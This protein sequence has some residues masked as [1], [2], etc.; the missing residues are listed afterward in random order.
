LISSAQPNLCIN[1]VAAKSS[2]LFF[3]KKAYQG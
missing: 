1:Q 3:A 2:I